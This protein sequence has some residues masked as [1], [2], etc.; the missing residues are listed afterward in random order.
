MKFCPLLLTLAL[1][2]CGPGMIVNNPVVLPPVTVSESAPTMGAMVSRSE[3]SS[4]ASASRLSVL[5]GSVAAAA[6]D[7]VLVPAFGLDA[8]APLN[9]GAPGESMTLGQVKALTRRGD[10]V[11]VLTNEGLFHE[12]SGRLLKSP[13]SAG[14]LPSGATFV[15]AW[16]TGDAEE[17][18][19]ISP[20]GI[21]QIAHQAVTQLNLQVPQESGAPSFAMGVGAGRA[22]VVVGT[23]VLT[24]DLAANKASVILKSLQ[25]SSVAR[26]DDGAI[27]LATDRGLFARDTDGTLR[28]AT[29]ANPGEAARPVAALAAGFGNLTAIVDNNVVSLSS[30]SPVIIQ[31]VTT[32]AAFGLVHDAQGDTFAVDV[33]KVVRFLTRK[34]VSF[35]DDLQPFIA[36]HCMSCH[37]TGAEGS[38]VVA[39]DTYAVAS[40]RADDIVKRVTANGATPMPPTSRERLSTADIALFTKW[41][42]GGKTP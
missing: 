26:M 33:D 29:F 14:G 19:V 10:G 32:P 41:V 16:G 20:S 3:L 9:V 35:A 23:T 15:D 13:L 5:H 6:A 21:A 37:A 8:L 7:A 18:W 38:T 34:P 12:A 27:A 39:F 1:S 36:A 2:A 4:S 22:V 17:L 30:G 25:V 31:T 40:A 42:A 24:V 11:L 28:Q